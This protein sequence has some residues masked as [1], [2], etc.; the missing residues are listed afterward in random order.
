MLTVGTLLESFPNNDSE[1]S[2]GNSF[3]RPTYAKARA[4]KTPTMEKAEVV[5]NM[6]R[7]DG[8]DRLG[9][10]LA[11]TLLHVMCDASTGSGTASSVR[12]PSVSC[13]R[14][15]ICGPAPWPAMEPPVLQDR[16]AQPGTGVKVEGRRE[17]NR[18][19]GKNSTFPESGAPADHFSLASLL[20]RW[21]AGRRGSQVRMC[22]KRETDAARKSA[23]VILSANRNGGSTQWVILGLS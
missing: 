10:A 4:P 20:S 3:T 5:V 11:V 23:R 1:G 9:K 12:C 21:N 22:R 2:F 14:F 7:P 6:R 8:F 15:N 18:F 19:P 16:Q 13:F 17:Q